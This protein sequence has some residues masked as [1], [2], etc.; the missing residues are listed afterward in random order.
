MTE[1][2]QACPVGAYSLMGE[3]G[4]PQTVMGQSG[5]SRDEGSTWDVGAHRKGLTRVQEGFSWT[6]EA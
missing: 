6:E 5:Q 3:T 2:A 1:T 4:C